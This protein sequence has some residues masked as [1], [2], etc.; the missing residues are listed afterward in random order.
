LIPGVL[1]RWLIYKPYRYISYKLR[2]ET[3][4]PYKDPWWIKEN[5]R[6]L[7]FD[8]YPFESLKRK[9]LIW[10][11]NRKFTQIKEQDLA[12]ERYGMKDVKLCE[13][14]NYARE[15][16]LASLTCYETLRNVINNDWV[17]ITTHPRFTSNNTK[18]WYSV[19]MYNFMAQANKE[20]N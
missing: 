5:F 8:Y 1:P 18:L 4:P 10:Q 11:I 13:T 2:G 20:I 15:R 12:F 6:C 16:G 14:K 7:R 3:P 19:M 17:K 9:W